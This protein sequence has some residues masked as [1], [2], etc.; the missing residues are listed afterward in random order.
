MYSVSVRTLI[1]TTDSS[2]YNLQFSHKIK[3]NHPTSPWIH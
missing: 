1:N 3:Q 2:F